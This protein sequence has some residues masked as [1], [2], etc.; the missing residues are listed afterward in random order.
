MSVWQEL[1]E[2]GTATVYEAAGRQ[3]LIDES[4]V[5]VVPGS[6]AGSG[7]PAG[8]AYGSAAGVAYG[9]PGR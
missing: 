8:A 7:K 5:Q 6:R 3:G 2:L 1:A 4:L 9:S